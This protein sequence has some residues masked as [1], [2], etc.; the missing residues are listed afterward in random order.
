MLHC[1]N[2]VRTFVHDYQEIRWYLRIQ[3]DHIRIPQRYRQSPAAQVQFCLE[4]TYHIIRS[5]DS[6]LEYNQLS[7]LFISIEYV[8]ATQEELKALGL[9]QLEIE[10]LINDVSTML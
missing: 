4:V 9:S 6:C 2:L 5:D 10:A 3:R 1:A 7:L 8:V